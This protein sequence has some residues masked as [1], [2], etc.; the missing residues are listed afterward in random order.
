MK[1]MH[2]IALAACVG[3]AGCGARELDERQTEVVQGLVYKLHDTEPF[4]GVVTHAKVPL[5]EMLIVGD[6]TIGYVNGVVD[7]QMICFASPDQKVYESHFS[8]E[9]KD[10]IEKR[11]N[12]SGGLTYEAS[13]KEG[14][15]HGR[16]RAYDK[17][18]KIL[19][20]ETQW[21]D[22]QKAG[23]DRYWDETGKRLVQDFV[24]SEG[25]A[26]GHQLATSNNG[27]VELTLK[28]GLLHGVR[29][30]YGRDGKIRIEQEFV[31]GLAD[32]N[33]HSFEGWSEWHRVWSK[34]H[35]KTATVALRDDRGTLLESSTLECLDD[36]GFQLTGPDTP[37][38]QYNYQN[39]RIVTTEA[40]PQ[41]RYSAFDFPSGSYQFESDATRYSLA[42]TGAMNWTF[43]EFGI[44]KFET[45]FERGVPVGTQRGWN[46][47][48]DL[49]IEGRREDGRLVEITGSAWP[50]RNEASSSAPE[51]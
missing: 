4:T 14:R 28:A 8:K 43:K 41:K 29:R 19:L 18:G 39:A 5:V 16:E 9:K 37:S 50:L 40:N 32:G 11:W 24:W 36:C 45:T 49:V 27:N 25:K 42:K 23:T 22:G 33:Q 48:G 1:G 12:T 38:F 15:K 44:A 46:E 7:G 30:E 26:T 47:R 34:G 31:D 3:L 13:W 35:L 21:S 20:V 10:G 6:C 51:G 17:T 2:F